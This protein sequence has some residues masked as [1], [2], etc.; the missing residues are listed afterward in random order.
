[1]VILDS[2]HTESHVIQELN[3][4]S[5][6]VSKKNYLIVQDTGIH[7]MPEKMNINRAWSKNNNPYTAVKKVF[8]K[9]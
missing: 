2:D 4:Y 8:K 6:I 3:I 7:Y 1:M 9:K 5:K